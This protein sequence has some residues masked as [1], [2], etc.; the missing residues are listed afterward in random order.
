M[1]SQKCL[2]LDPVY[3]DKDNIQAITQKNLDITI[4]YNKLF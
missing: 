3:G 4:M 1:C 2:L